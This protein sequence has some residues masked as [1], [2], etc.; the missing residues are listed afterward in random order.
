MTDAWTFCGEG[1]HNVNFLS[2][3]LTLLIRRVLLWCAS[4]V[5]L[6]NL[7]LSRIGDYI[8]REICYVVYVGYC[9]PFVCLFVY[10][11]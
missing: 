10:S 3:K 11:Q 2:V 9:L 7:G 6:Y 5:V 4:S 1:T 8:G